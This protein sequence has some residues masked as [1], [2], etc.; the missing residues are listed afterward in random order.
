MIGFMLS[1]LFVAFVLR[2]RIVS[3]ENAFSE[4]GK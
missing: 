1:S 2:M 4:S 3:E